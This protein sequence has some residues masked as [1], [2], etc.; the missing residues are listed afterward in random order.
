M[1]EKEKKVR[2]RFAPSPTGSIHLGNLRT[3]LFAWLFARNKQG[4]FLVR[5][6]DTDRK[7]LEEDSL[8]KIF[9]ALRWANLDIDEGVFLN[10]EGGISQKGNLGPYIQSERL[11][12]Y[13]KYIQELLE[14]DKAYHCFC[15]EERLKEVQEKQ[16]AEKQPIMYDRHCRNLSLEEVQTRIQNGEK[17]VIRMKVPE[18][19]IVSFTDQV[20]GKIFVKSEIIDDQVLIK[21]DGFPTYHFAVVVDD[22]LMKISHVFRG[23]EWIP[24]TPKHILLYQFFQW[25]APVFIHLPSVLGEDKKKLSKRGGAVSVEDFIKKGYLPEALVNFLVLLGW[26]SKTEQEVFSQKDLIEKF[27]LDGLNKAGAIL[28]YQKLDWFNKEYLRTMEK[29]D[30]E[31]EVL[32]FLTDDLKNRVE[33]N[34]SIFKKVLPVIRERIEKFEDVTRMAEAG[35]LSYYFNLPNYKKEKLLWKGEGNLIE[36]KDYLVKVVSFLDEVG[37]FTAENIKSN[38]WGYATEQ[39]RG[40]VLWPMRYALSGQDKS[41]DPFVLAEILGKEETLNRLKYAIEKI[42]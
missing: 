33:Q 23:E 36:T 21:T 22:H 4:S 31:K 30:F 14:N 39:G 25:K 34:P 37:E 6:E 12:I 41:P 3:A 24:S 38:I 2:V 13:Q 11:E 35:E 1:E 29:D 19:E 7:R 40:L 27:N 42:D 17:Y 28:N 18:N 15:S 5:V 32:M 16:Q 20:F 9:E 10:D 26:N 8:K